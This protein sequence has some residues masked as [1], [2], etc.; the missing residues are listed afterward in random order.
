MEADRSTGLVSWLLRFWGA[1]R[2]DERA[3]WASPRAGAWGA[4]IKGSAAPRVA[5]GRVNVEAV[6]LQGSKY[7]RHVSACWDALAFSDSLDC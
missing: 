5:Q 3:A 1:M 6:T 2:S 7:L 4:A